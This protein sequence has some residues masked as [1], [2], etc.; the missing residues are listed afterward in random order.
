MA[1]SI[2]ELDGPHVVPTDLARGPWSPDAQHGGAPAALL[3][4]A[5]ERFDG[6]DAMV[7]T[8]LTVELLRPVPI[9]PLL[10]ETR[11]SRPGKKLQLVEA[12]LLVA[13][14]RTEVARATGLRLRRARV[15]LPE[16]TAPYGT[17]PLPSTGV[18][19]RPPWSGQIAYD[20]FHSG[21][22]EMRFVHGTFGEPGPATAWIRLRVPLVAGEATSPL[23][24]V[25]AAADFG[26]GVSWVLSRSLGYRFIN[27]DLTIYLHRHPEGEWV[28]LE[29]VTLPGDLG[30]GIAESRLYDERGP[31][32]RSVQCLL[33]ERE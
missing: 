19:S 3:G 15:Q 6:G 25:A 20:G 29:S 32:G 8:R 16:G 27:P 24:R 21:G 28:A 17:P 7:V 33:I 31:L 26:N 11:F 1:D 13:G 18:A 14:T 30:V 10:I 5:V 4:R 12:S 9:A 22:T 23:C 2:F